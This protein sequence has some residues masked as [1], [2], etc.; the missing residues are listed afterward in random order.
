MN[1]TELPDEIYKNLSRLTCFDLENNPHL[2]VTVPE[3]QSCLSEITF[4]N[5]SSFSRF[6]F[7]ETEQLAFLWLLFFFIVVGNS[8]VLLALVLAKG[9]RSRMN[10][11]ITHLAIADLSVGL[12]S[13]ATDIAWKMTVV[14]YA[15]NVACKIIRFSQVLVTYS[16]TYV[17]IALSIDRCDAISHPMNF[18]GGWR[19]AKILVSSSWILSA[20]FSSPILFLYERKV[21]E[22]KPQCWIDLQVWQWKLYMTLVA[23]ALF[24]IP[25]VIISGCYLIIVYTIW[26]K[27]L[28]MENYKS[29][30]PSSSTEGGSRSHPSE[31]L[32]KRVSSRGVIPRAK[33]KTV[34]MTFVIV[35]V[36]V[37]CWSPY[38][39]FD[40]L[41]VYGH[42][43]NT[44]TM[45]AV[46]TFIQS[47]APLNSATNPLVY[48]LFSTR[49]CRNLRKIPL[50][51][52][53][54]RKTID[55]LQPNEEQIVR[56][57]PL[58]LGISR[59]TS[60]D[61][62]QS[63]T[64]SSSMSKHPAQS[65]SSAKRKPS[66]RLS[67]DLNSERLRYM[68]SKENVGIFDFEV[69]TG[70]LLIANVTDEKSISDVMASN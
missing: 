6:Y 2:N 12:I 45:I 8:A 69:V 57:K 56:G 60:S 5:E 70:A 20:I 68:K 35:T 63:T 65:Q 15:G 67:G 7:Y 13:V 34:K 64:L 23:L 55:C 11:F 33:L 32:E 10:Y 9:R 66:K 18:S 21:I 42:L 1:S 46:A 49:L 62:T 41:Q 22:G 4:L 29:H 58:G 30:R 17:L 25:T 40:L 14:W 47:L 54:A 16:S 50:F 61:P 39:I 38:I 24:I 59:T 36:F 3:L 37:L 52:W 44:Q 19:R 27:S 51:D 26:K 53:V 31:E 48:C 43:P 28:G